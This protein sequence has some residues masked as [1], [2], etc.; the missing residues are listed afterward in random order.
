MEGVDHLRP[1]ARLVVDLLVRAGGE[2]GGERV[3]DRQQAVAREAGRGRDHVLLGDP[4]L[5][6]AIRVRQLERT[7]AAVG[8]EVGVEDDQVLTL[9]SEADEFVAVRVDDVLV[10]HAGRA[11]AGSRLGLALERLGSRLRLGVHWSERERSEAS[12]L[13]PLPEAAGDLGE[14]ALE[15]LVVGRARVPAVGPAALAAAPPGAP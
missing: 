3:H 5:D 15:R 1:L 8:G 13:Q 11:R 6:E 2:E 4:A 14:R 7:H 10:R 9:G 12:R